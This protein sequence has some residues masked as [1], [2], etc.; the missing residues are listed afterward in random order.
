MTDSDMIRIERHET[1][2]VTRYEITLNQLDKQRSRVG[3]SVRHHWD[4]GIQ[5]LSALAMGI[6]TPV[7]ACCR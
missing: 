6:R 5:V 4:P 7:S 1:D 3:V 2:E